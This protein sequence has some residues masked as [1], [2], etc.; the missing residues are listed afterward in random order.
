MSLEAR[1][2]AHCV[3]LKIDLDFAG[4]WFCLGSNVSAHLY[5][6]D[7]SV[8]GEPPSKAVKEGLALRKDFAQTHPSIHASV[9]TLEE[10]LDPVI[11]CE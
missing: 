8:M 7:L 1:F 3:Q 5:C 2:P 6:R 9:H 11:C 4:S 10:L